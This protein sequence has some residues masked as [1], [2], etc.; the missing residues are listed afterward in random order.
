MVDYNI[1]VPQQQ[2]YQA[3]DP[4]QNFL[5]MQQIQM[6]NAQMQELARKRSE[7]DALRGITADPSSP[8][9]IQQLARISPELGMKALNMQRQNTLLDTQTRAAGLSAAKTGQ[10]IRL[11]GMDLLK[12]HTDLLPGVIGSDKPA[13]S[14][15]TW[16]ASLAKD[17][18]E[19]PANVPTVY[20]GAERARAIMDRANEFLTRT[21]P[22]RATIGGVETEYSPG[23]GTARELAVVPFNPNA[24]VPSYPMRP[25]AAA[26]MAQRGAKYAPDLV[27]GAAPVNT[28]APANAVAAPVNAMATPPS[29]YGALVGASQLQEQQKRQESERAL[30]LDLAKKRGE[31]QVTQQE[32]AKVKLPQLED[33]A[34]QALKNIEG[35]IGSAQVD[36]KGKVVVPK[37]GLPLH[38]GFG[39]STG[40]TFSKLLTSE[41]IAGTSRADFVARFEQIKGSTFLDAYNA[42]RGGGAIDQ[43]EGE[44]ATA[45]LNRMNLK[46][47]EAE[48]IR[49]AREFE[50][51]I[52]KGVA[53]ARAMA[54]G[55][56]GSNMTSA[57]T[58]APQAKP[59]E[60]QVVRTGTLNGRRVVQ[61]SDGATEYAD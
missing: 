8:E 38:P 26:D 18:G 13:E 51:V 12:K 60:R 31:T 44:K 27:G 39:S 23:T 16:R 42:L 56:A 53:R 30:A 36:A 4:M 33:A 50:D 40:T 15:A 32:S 24:G 5:R 6:H 19:D 10:D 3:P 11:G 37:D 1:A 2:L 47:S 20:P 25:A 43:K 57:A 41:P 48:F 35:L 34:N 54:Q 14:W 22:Q 61:Y 7:E 55:G 28:M 49:A 17:A 29:P 9:Y 59:A 21:A 45:A 52:K 58:T 46:Q